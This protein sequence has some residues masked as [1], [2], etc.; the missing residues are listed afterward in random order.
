MKKIRFSFFT[1]QVVSEDTLVIATQ[2]RELR[3]MF[4][5]KFY[6]QV[7][8]REKHDVENVSNETLLEEFEMETAL[9][10]LVIK[11]WIEDDQFKIKSEY[12]SN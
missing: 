11:S 2:L 10:F 8:Q 7:L 3:I 1:D 12:I 5:D 6:F 4:R 9:N